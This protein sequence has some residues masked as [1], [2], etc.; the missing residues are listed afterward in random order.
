MKLTLTSISLSVF[1][2]CLSLWAQESPQP[3]TGGGL[4]VRFKQLDRNGDGTVTREEAAQLPVFDQW[5]ANKD[6]CRVILGRMHGS[7]GQLSTQQDSRHPDDEVDLA[8]L[9]RL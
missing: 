5:D 3:T 6:H 2:G 8:E 4:A 7:D 1:L 9:T